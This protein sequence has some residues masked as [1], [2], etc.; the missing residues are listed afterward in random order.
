M[1]SLTNT[2]L[3]SLV[4]AQG[5]DQQPNT[6]DMNTAVLASVADERINGDNAQTFTDWVRIAHQNNGDFTARQILASQ[7]AD[8]ELDNIIL[9]ETEANTAVFISRVLGC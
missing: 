1:E 7:K 4:L 5:E 8:Q 6:R 2:E 3:P 9:S